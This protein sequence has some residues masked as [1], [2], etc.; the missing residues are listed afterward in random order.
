MGNL[1]STQPINLGEKGDVASN[2]RF[3]RPT[4]VR[5]PRKESEILD[6]HRSYGVHWKKVTLSIGVIGVGCEPFHLPPPY[7]DGLRVT[8]LQ[9]G[10][11]VVFPPR[12]PPRHRWKNRGRDQVFR[13]RVE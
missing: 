12:L 2:Q 8:F 10:L 11:V 5:A 1:P 13:Q 4:L 3:P 7:F 9:W 6:P